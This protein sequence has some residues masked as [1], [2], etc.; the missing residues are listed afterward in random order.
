MEGA[1]PLRV[2]KETER[3]AGVIEELRKAHGLNVGAVAE[4]KAVV[5]GLVEATVRDWEQFLRQIYRPTFQGTAKEGLEG[6]G[7]IQQEPVT[8]MAGH[9]IAFYLLPQERA[10]RNPRAFAI[11]AWPPDRDRRRPDPRGIPPA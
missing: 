4:L 7:V 1:R 2:K 8:M 3:M 10:G 9:E 6:M 5:P 11:A